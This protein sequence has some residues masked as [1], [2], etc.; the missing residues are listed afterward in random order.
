M[1]SEDSMNDYYNRRADEYEQ[2]YFR[3][4]PKRRKEIDDEVLRLIYLSKDKDILEFACG[5][6]YWTS[7]ISETAKTIIAFDASSEMIEN[8]KQ[9]HYL[10]PTDF[11]QADLNNIPLQ[12]IQ[13]DLIC[14]GFW[15]SHH[16]RQSY[17]N[18]F[19]TIKKHLKC[20]GKIWMI[21]NNPPAE[22]PLNYSTG[23]DEHGN[24]YKK[25]FLDNGESF[26]II[27]NYF[28]QK[29]LVEIFSHEFNIERLTYGE[30]YWAIE[31]SIK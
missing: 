20:N 26:I 8:A 19:E 11:I 7:R 24:N 15:F 10:C 18:L 13:F 22:G 1:K 16:P 21:D 9:K 6:G 25:R 31:L 2:I 12:N 28:T 29:E 4:I 30:Y 17:G 5:T 27:K 3:K 23:S 14:L